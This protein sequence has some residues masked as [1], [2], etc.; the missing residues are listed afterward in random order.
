[1][2]I[3]VP[4]ICPKTLG[5][6]HV[7]ARTVE[8]TKKTNSCQRFDLLSEF[9][10]CLNP[11]ENTGFLEFSVK[12][13]VPFLKIT[14]SSEAGLNIILNGKPPRCFVG[15]M[16]FVNLPSLFCCQKTFGMTFG[17]YAT[18]SPQ[19]YQSKNMTHF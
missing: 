1:M 8:N 11:G 5:C 12:N 15:F 13:G 9:R 6:Q 3:S 7:G 17:K 2:N 10:P 18:P 16:C 4:W 14:T 19:L